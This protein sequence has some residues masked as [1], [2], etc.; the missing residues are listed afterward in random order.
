MGKDDKWVERNESHPFCQVFDSANQNVEMEYDEFGIVIE[1]PELDHS[2]FLLQIR[3]HIMDE[4][5]F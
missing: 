5:M 1:D 4:S 3:Q 2:I